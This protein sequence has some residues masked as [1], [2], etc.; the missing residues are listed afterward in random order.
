MRATLEQAGFAPAGET[1]K[2]LQGGLIGVVLNA[3]RDDC[4]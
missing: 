2:G 3:Y 1:Y 4:A